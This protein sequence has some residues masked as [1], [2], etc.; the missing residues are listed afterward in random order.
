MSATTVWISELSALTHGALAADFPTLQAHAAQSVV[1]AAICSP[2]SI[3]LAAA[4]IRF[5]G[6]HGIPLLPRGGGTA[7]TI[8]NPPPEHA[9]VLSTKNLTT[10]FAHEPSDIIATIPAGMT[11]G[12]A[13][14]RLQ[15]NGQWLP[16]DGP[17]AATIG[18]LTATDRSGPL[19][20][21]YGTLRDMVIGMTV[22]NGDGEIRKCGGKVVKNVTG[23][24]LD[25][26]YIGSLG[27]LGLITDVTFKLRPLP[28]GRQTWSIPA[29]NVE[30]ASTILRAIAR[31]NLP[32]ESLRALHSK[33]KSPRIAA[34]AAGTAAELDRIHAEITA[35]SAPQI[36]ARTTATLQWEASSAHSTGQSNP[37]KP[38]EN[39]ATLRFWCRATSLD[40]VLP[41]LEPLSD[42][43][44][45]HT[46]GGSAALKCSTQQAV[47]LAAKLAAAGANL[48][49]DNVH[50]LELRDRFGPPRP[51]WQLM[52]QIRVALDPKQIMNPDRFVV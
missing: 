45:F 8:G 52:K 44:E 19:A 25:K 41:L 1:P 5:A 34:A 35:S 6:A 40:T 24:A 36:P 18:G 27:T 51:D 22:I 9:L 29:A 39:G 42:C 10:G 50:G 46:Q 28:I 21:G 31:K 30:S 11:L 20:H 49:F 3:E 14:T 7:Q 23:Y 43:M 48:R 26:L 16:L 37:D 32:L 2:T 4:A 47:D 33:N 15:Q 17:A 38:R 12:E 13:Q